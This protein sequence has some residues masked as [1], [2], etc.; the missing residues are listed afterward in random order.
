MPKLHGVFIGIDRYA[1]P[2]INWL[3]CARRDATAL[4]ALF[5]D[6]L[7][8]DL[9]LLTD[10][11]ATRS[12]LEKE[13]KSLSQCAPDDIVVFAF[14]GHGTETHELVTYDTDRAKLSATTISLNQ[15]GEHFSKIPA[16]RLICIL[17]CCFSG[18]MGAKAL[19]VDVVPRD[20][21][22][23][24]ELLKQ[25][26]G[27]GRVI[28]TA[29]LA[30]E[31]AWEHQK[32][33]HGLLTHYLLEALQGAEEVRKSGKV[34]LYKLLDYV[35][36]KVIDSAKIFGEEQHPVLL[37]QIKEEIT[38]PIFKP[39]K[40]YK[41][42]FPERD[43]RKVTPDVQSLS[44]F[45]F[46][47]DL[48]KAWAGSSIT[49]LNQLQ[50]D[51]INEFKVLDGEHLV[52]SAPTSAG[53]TLI[54]ELAALQGVI[55][56]KRA[57]FLLPLK[58]LVND[59]LR[60][61]EETYGAFGLRTIRAT[62]ESTSDD[63][64]PLMRGQYDI[65]LMT[66]E[67]FSA[68]IL[69]SPH[70]LDQ[71][72]TIVVDEVQMI[73]D[74]SRGVN[75]EFILTLLRMRRKQGIEPQVI[76][77]S[78]VIGDTNGFERW[79][80]ARLLRRTERPVPL[81]EGIVRLDGT[82]RY[83]ESD[84][85]KEKTVQSAQTQFRKGSGQDVIIPLVGKLVKDGKSVIVFR[86]TKSEAQACALYLARNLGLPPAQVAVDNLPNTDPSISSQKL[87]ETLNGGVAFH[88]SDLDAE[89]RRL[90]EEQ[91]RASSSALK[92]IAA[93]T[94][95]AMG[96]NTP[97]E[98]VIIA[99]LSH[100]GDVPYSV[101]EYKNIA[102]RAGRL[103]YTT[104]GSSFLVALTPSEE[105]TLWTNYIQA[106][107]EDLHSKFFADNTDPRSLVIRVLVAVRSRRG[108]TADEI[109]EFLEESF[110]SF[111]EKIKNPAWAWDKNQIT[112]AIEELRTHRL[113]EQDKDG[114]YHPTPLG[115]LAG[116]SGLEVE[117]VL[118]VVSALQGIQQA[119]IS[120]PALIAL[121]QVTVELDQVLFPLNKRSTQK[122]P[123]TWMTEVRNQ[124]IP[125]NIINAFH[126][127]IQDQT[128]ATRRAKKAVACLLW[129][130]DKPLVEIENVLMQFDRADTAAG[131][132]RSVSAR[133]CDVLS[134]VARIAELLNPGFDLAA[135][136][137]R[138]L[139]RLEIGIPAGVVELG[140]IFGRVFNR[141]DYLCLMKN[142]ITTKE[143]FEAAKEDA[144]LQCLE[145][146]REKLAAAKVRLEEYEREEKPIPGSPILPE[147]EG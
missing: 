118:R 83:I 74:K 109:V 73:A 49:T 92:V 86:E 54:G 146:N 119:D 107:P 75:L 141:G 108:L 102:G 56:R 13:L 106:N 121:T 17:D 81:D 130:T 65:C 59:K 76:A 60:H 18:G 88:I 47:D 133:V 71:V 126:R 110:G 34:G 7:P 45:G 3:S 134:T 44:A 136:V 22:S 23:G 145:N 62:G 115:R 112:A 42:A 9:K 78:A 79:L 103:G 61:F 37:G 55:E 105:H 30:T 104:R 51:A 4:H 43:T 111:Q 117:S 124:R 128:D 82:F 32:L 68:M 53:K 84:T 123:Q 99:G 101:A 100:P 29:S 91:F 114:F 143:A 50:V 28:L 46:P 96:V 147:Y 85:G 72:S 27:D 6:N 40:L 113:I 36:T 20:I 1:S 24:E 138:L 11:D 132:I 48:L 116:E 94:T 89:E 139:V 90:I 10:K 127:S 16:R 64:L 137:E 2:A 63:I 58:A 69:G 122:E 70:I 15:L 87:R 77:L 52:V 33:G 98:A 131:A 12:T 80:G 129:I 135:R 39:G 26:S 35:T 93:T 67:K 41:E 14:S 21:P 57:L 66:Y 5:A 38:L 25:L 140:S 97:T 8:G 144:L 120:D 31:K 19:Q 95:L 142:G 125:G